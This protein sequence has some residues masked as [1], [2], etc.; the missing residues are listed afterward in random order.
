[1]R[2]VLLFVGND[3]VVGDSVAAD[4][5]AHQDDAVRGDAVRFRAVNEHMMHS[6]WMCGERGESLYDPSHC[7][8]VA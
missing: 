7:C 4:S 6:D 2:F 8:W 1:M 3:A 5:P